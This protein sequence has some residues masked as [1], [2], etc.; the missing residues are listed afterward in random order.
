MGA[1][2][3]IGIDWDAFEFDQHGRAVDTNPGDGMNRAEILQVLTAPDTLD[4]RFRFALSSDLGGEWASP[5]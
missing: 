1:I 4:G 5:P 3:G 2:A